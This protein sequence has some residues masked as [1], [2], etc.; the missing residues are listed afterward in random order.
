VIWSVETQAN[1]GGGVAISGSIPESVF[2]AGTCGDDRTT[3]Y[4]NGSAE[5]MAGRAAEQA[6]EQW[7]SGTFDPGADSGQCCVGIGTVIA[8]F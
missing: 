6:I 1:R 3:W 5:L 4:A 8:I 7:A 2:S